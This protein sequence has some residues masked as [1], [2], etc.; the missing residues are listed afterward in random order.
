[1]AGNWWW[2]ILGGSL[3]VVGVVGFFVCLQLGVPQVGR[4]IPIIFAAAGSIVLAFSVFQD[5][6]VEWV[7][8]FLA[9]IALF[10]T[11]AAIGGPVSSDPETSS[12]TPPSPS[13]PCERG[14]EIATTRDYHYGGF[15][16]KSATYNI[17]RGRDSG[18]LAYLEL[19]GEISG[20]VPTGSGL[21]LFA[22]ADPATVDR[23]GN[24]GNGLYQWLDEYEI[25][26]DASGCWSLPSIPLGYPGYEGITVKY[27]P[28]VI[29]RAQESCLWKLIQAEVQKDEHRDGLLYVQLNKQ[30]SISFLGYA[31][32][33]TK[34]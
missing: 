27:Y 2:R 20:S 23:E 26:R 6:R 29:S 9:L 3:V 4:L 10:G 17:S 34:R 22:W 21:Y 12:P 28:A 8:I 24:P 18:E 32:V 25:S 13:S 14:K 11:Y 15:S 19:L 30:C 33:P 5:K 16:L 1:V 7:A 31:V